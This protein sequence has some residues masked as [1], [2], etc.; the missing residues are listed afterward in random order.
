MKRSGSVRSD[1]SGCGADPLRSGACC[2]AGASGPDLDNM[3][4][5]DP[6]TPGQ[7]QQQACA[8]ISFR[9]GKTQMERVVRDCGTYGGGAAFSVVTCSLFLHAVS[10]AIG[11]Q[12][13][14]LSALFS[15]QSRS[16]TIRAAPASRGPNLQA[17]VS[18]NCCQLEALLDNN[19]DRDKMDRGRLDAAFAI[20]SSLCRTDDA[21]RGL[22][23][24]A[25]VA[26]E[27]E[28]RR[29]DGELRGCLHYKTAV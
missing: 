29:V 11:K 12:D 13:L 6:E 10:T 4:R 8:S 28:Q 22:L 19:T 21:R 3:P 26:L 27:V 25:P 5:P 16:V 2:R 7:Q 14:E 18:D 24:S 20:V 1:L 17:L 23:G 9:I 15:V